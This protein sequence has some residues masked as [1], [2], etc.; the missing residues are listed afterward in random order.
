MLN[1]SKTSKRRAGLTIDLETARGDLSGDQ[2][3]VLNF[4]NMFHL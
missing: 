2:V 3:N 1:G 4:P